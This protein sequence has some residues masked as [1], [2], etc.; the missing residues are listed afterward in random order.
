VSEAR[1]SEQ[2]EGHLHEICAEWQGFRMND[3]EWWGPEWAVREVSRN[4]GDSCCMGDVKE[5]EGKG[6]RGSGL[7]KTLC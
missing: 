5:S 7:H 4:S 6:E 2:S 1:G 3:A